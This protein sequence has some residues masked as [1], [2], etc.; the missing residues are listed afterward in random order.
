METLPHGF[1]AADIWVLDKAI[2]QSELGVGASE[3]T[4]GVFATVSAPSH[5]GFALESDDAPQAVDSQN[6]PELNRP[7]E[8]LSSSD[9]STSKLLCPENRCKTTSEDVF[10]DIARET[11]LAAASRRFY[12]EHV[13]DA[14]TAE[15]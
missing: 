9:M 3:W 12:S 11:Q 15:F 14:S 1:Q 8:T 5:D 4:T 7:A 2:S 10:E 6:R 13:Q